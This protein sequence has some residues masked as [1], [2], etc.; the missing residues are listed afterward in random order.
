MTDRDR[1]RLLHGP[2]APPPL[3]KGGRTTRLLRDCTGFDGML[4]PVSPVQRYR[5]PAR[6]AAAGSIARSALP[7][8]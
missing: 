1:V 3:R 5:P 7:A 2:Y 8:H 6:F 4:E